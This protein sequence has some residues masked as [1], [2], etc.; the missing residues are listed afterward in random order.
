MN[1]K[2][3]FDD[4]FKSTER[5]GCWPVRSIGQLMVVVAAC[6]LTF[7]AVAG[8]AVRKK[9][10]RPNAARIQGGVLRHRVKALPAPRRDSFL[11][12]AAPELDA[13]MVVQ[14]PTE[15]DAA[16]VFNPD[17]G[18]TQRARA[19]AAQ[20]SPL[21]PAPGNQPGRLPGNFYPP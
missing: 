1:R 12:A 16:M 18:E 11:I 4:D 17:F 20:A 5:H 8:M 15:I 10:A 2:P 21:T 14:A 9:I 6:A 19:P 13:T 3:G 7:T